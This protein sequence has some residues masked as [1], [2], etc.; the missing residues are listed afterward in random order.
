MNIYERKYLENHILTK[1]KYGDW[2][3]PPESL[4]LIKSKDSLRTTDGALI[5]T[6]YYYRLLQHMKEFAALAGSDEDE[7]AYQELGE[8]IKVAFNEKFFNKQKNFYGNNSVTANIL[9]CILGWRR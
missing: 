7:A 8:K 2:C 4:E 5:A 9:P 6:A 1:D 3:V